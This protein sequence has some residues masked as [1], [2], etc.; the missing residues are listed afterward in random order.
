MRPV[1]LAVAMAGFVLLAR[2]APGSLT[3]SSTKIEGTAIAG[4]ES[5]D[6]SFT[7]KNTGD[8]PVRFISVKTSCGCTTAATAKATYA[9]GETGELKA[10]VNLRGRSG[11]QEKI[12]T[13]TTDDAPNAP[14][15]LIVGIDVPS[16]VDVLPRLLVWSHGSKAEPK[17]VSIAAGSTVEIFLRNVQCGNPQFIV[18]QITDHPGS[19]Y[20]LRITPRSTDSTMRTFIHFDIGTTLDHPDATTDDEVVYLMVE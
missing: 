11:H 6:A 7:F 15:S 13:I 16:I 20:R 10:Q 8:K 1:R 18:E 4:Q 14:V 3:W 9:P 12:I 17:E 5:F 19:R 2:M